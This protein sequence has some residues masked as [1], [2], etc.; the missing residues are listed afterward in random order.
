MKL[1]DILVEWDKDS[2]IDQTELAQES[3]KIA[4]L[5]S[6]YYKIFLAERMQLKKWKGE[7][8]QLYKLKYEY[9]NGTISDED[10]KLHDWQPFALKILKNDISVYIEADS[11]IINSQN[12]VEM[13]EEKINFLESAIKS[14][15]A[16]GYNIKSA[17]DWLKWTHGG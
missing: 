3:L 16:R 4:Q 6:K 17:I 10:L 13:Q 9:Y 7:F 8:K 15:T 1:E 14:L 12:R 11:D 2:K 5:H